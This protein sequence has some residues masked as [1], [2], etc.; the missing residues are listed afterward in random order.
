MTLNFKEFKL[1]KDI[2]T[3]K[4]KVLSTAFGLSSIDFLKKFKMEYFKIPS[5]EINNVLYLKKIGKLKESN[6]IYRHV[7]YERNFLCS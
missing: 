5:G 3:K 1:L 7:N 2:V 4:N 6:F